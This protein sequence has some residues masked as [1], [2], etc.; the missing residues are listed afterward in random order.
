[1]KIYEFHSARVFV[2]LAIAC[3]LTALF[4]PQSFAATNVSGGGGQQ[5]LSVGQAG[6]KAVDLK[7]WTDKAKDDQAKLGAPAVVR[8]K[9]SEKAYLTSIYVSPNGD[10]IVLLPNRD[11]EDSLIL[12][13]KEYTLFGPECQVKLKESDT[14][15]DAKIV[16]Y[17]SSMPL[18]TDGLTIPPGEP[19]IR[20]PQ[21]STDQ[22][23]ILTERLE[24]LAKD[25][26]FNRK[27][28]ALNSGEK[29]A[30]RLDLMGLPTDVKSAK[31][32]G[33]TGVQGLKTKIL[34]VGKE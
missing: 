1:M 5:L 14:A 12:P 4:C 30:S 9:A 28:L 24:A 27:V 25:P 17:V 13:D 10:A 19:F 26:G 6:A 20:I 31:P 15:K 8:V 29:K 23:K 3:A 2:C 34:E 32:M 21:S 7:V 11:L 18:K 22:I 16:F 33:V